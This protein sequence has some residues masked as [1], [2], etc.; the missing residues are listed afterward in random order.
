VVVA[1]Q[2]QHAAMRRGAG[3]VGVAEHVAGPVDARPLAVPD[4]EHAV[5][6]AFAAQFGLLRAPAGCRGQFLV[7]PGLEN[8]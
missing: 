3:Q 1:H 4:A 7:E 2:G 6:L 8:G 5:V